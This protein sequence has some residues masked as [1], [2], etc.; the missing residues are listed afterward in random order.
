MVQK[1]TPWLNVIRKPTSC[2]LGKL[3]WKA[4]LR[5]FSALCRRNQRKE[6]NDEPEQ[7]LRARER[8]PVLAFILGI[9]RTSAHKSRD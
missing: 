7:T 4:Y 6:V 2:Y 1:L 3:G 8:R 9:R 5:A